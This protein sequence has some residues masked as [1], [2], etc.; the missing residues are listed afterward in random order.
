[1]SR[2]DDTDD[3]GACLT[4]A[5]VPGAPLGRSGGARAGAD[6]SI[7]VLRT[8]EHEPGDRLTCRR[9]F[10]DYYRCN[11]WASGGAAAAAGRIDAHIICGLEVATFRVRKSQLVKATMAEGQLVVEDATNRAVG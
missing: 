6:R 8:L 4:G 7:E 9:V 1:M 2:D 10:G 11:W 5:A 3:P